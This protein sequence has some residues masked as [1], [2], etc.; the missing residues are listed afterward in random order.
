MNIGKRAQQCNL[1][2]EKETVKEKSKKKKGKKRRRER[3][4]KMKGGREC[5]KKIKI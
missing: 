4:D 5:K 2:G 3:K 1:H